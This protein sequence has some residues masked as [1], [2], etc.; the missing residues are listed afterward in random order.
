M[1]DKNKMERMCC[2]L[3]DVP[4]HNPLG[5]TPIYSDLLKNVD[6]LF[7]RKADLEERL[8]TTKQLSIEEKVGLIANLYNETVPALQEGLEKLRIDLQHKIDYSIKQDLERMGGEV[9]K[10]ILRTE[11]EKEAAVKNIERYVSKINT[12]RE[13]FIDICMDEETRQAYFVADAIIGE[14]KLSRTTLRLVGQATIDTLSRSVAQKWVRA[15]NIER[16]IQIYESMKDYV[17]AAKVLEMAGNKER[18]KKFWTLET[19]EYL[20]KHI[21]GGQK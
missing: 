17:S 10:Y 12:E 14:K 6:L 3:L 19:E 13:E 18:T 15:N 21:N 8:E 2:S 1:E 20:S 11:G 5:R 9:L 4:A 7:Q 16:A